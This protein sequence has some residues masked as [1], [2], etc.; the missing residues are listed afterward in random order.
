MEQVITKEAIVRM[1]M[2]EVIKVNGVVCEKN[3][4]YI[5]MYGRKATLYDKSGKI[6]LNHHITGRWKALKVNL[7]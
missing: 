2:V 1:E 6:V 3:G 4:K 7:G 5:E